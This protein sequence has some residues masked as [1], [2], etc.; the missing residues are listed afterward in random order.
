MDR[1]LYHTIKNFARLM[2]WTAIGAAVGWALPN[3]ALWSAEHWGS[4][5][6][7]IAP[8]VI[9]FLALLSFKLGKADTVTE[10][11]RNSQVYDKLREGDANERV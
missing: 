8:V 1:V 4:P 6:Y 3:M 2:F 11:L 10:E 5:L 9:A 7:V